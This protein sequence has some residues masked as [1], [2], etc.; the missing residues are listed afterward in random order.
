MTR[1]HPP[2][3]GRVRM[4]GGGQTVDRADAEA[5]WDAALCAEVDPDSVDRTTEVRLTKCTRWG[6]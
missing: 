3:F 6:L 2:T 4:F 5:V 1:P